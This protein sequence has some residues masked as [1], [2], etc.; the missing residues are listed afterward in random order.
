MKDKFLTFLNKLKNPK[1]WVL[2]V[3]YLI[4]LLA[5][6]GTIVL[7]VINSQKLVLQIL[8]YCL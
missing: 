3:W 4:T 2:V 1:P 5:V 8:S 6:A 7:L